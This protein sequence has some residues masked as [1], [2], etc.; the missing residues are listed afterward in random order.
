MTDAFS[1]SPPSAATRVS[2]AS[3]AGNLSVALTD[4][5]EGVRRWYV[6]HRMGWQDTKLRYRRSMLGPFWLSISMGIMMI[7]LGVLY[8]SLFKINIHDYMPFLA[9]GLVVWGLISTTLIEGCSVFIDAEGLIRNVSLPLSTY[10]YRILWRNL[11]VFAHN[12]V[13][14]FGTALWFGLWPGM[15]MMLLAVVGLLLFLVNAI[16]AV[17]LMGILSARFRDIPPVVTS[18]IQVLFFFTP[19]IWK[20]ELVADRVAL[21]HFNPFAHMVE[22]MRAPLLGQLP[23]VENWLTV[24]AMAIIGWAVTLRLYMRL[25]HRISYWV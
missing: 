16:W 12:L 15:G 8:S 19:V 11:I 24:I 9:A 20:P 3:Q 6:W 4:L 7:A 10:V 23:N 14:Y 13:V 25:R 2:D 18:L 5:R 17:L 21:I 1:V 22:V